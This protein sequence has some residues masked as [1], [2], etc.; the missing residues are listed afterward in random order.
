MTSLN[1]TLVEKVAHEAHRLTAT[2]SATLWTA[3][4]NGLRGANPSQVERLVAL[5]RGDVDVLTAA[6]RRVPERYKDSAGIAAHRLLRR[7]ALRAF[8]DKLESETEFPHHIDPHVSGVSGG[9]GSGVRA[10]RSGSATT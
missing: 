3:L 7:A 2:E 8:N 5:A 9:H 6:A 10:S 4:L 1:Q